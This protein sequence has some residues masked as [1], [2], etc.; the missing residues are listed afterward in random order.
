MREVGERRIARMRDAARVQCAPASDSRL[1]PDSVSRIPHRVEPRTL[2]ASGHRASSVNDLRSNGLKHRL[3]M[4][5]TLQDTVMPP[6]DEIP[7]GTLDML[8]LRTLA[9]RDG[10]A[11]VRDRRVHSLRLER[12]AAGGGRVALP[13][14]A[15]HAH[16]GVDRGRVGE[17]RGE[18]AGAILPAHG[19]RQAAARARNRFVPARGAAPS[20]SSSGRREARS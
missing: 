20:R 17:D 5:R 3:S 2:A 18:P 4:S 11:R 9:R 7:P 1:A 14:A 15:A 19:G 10:P 12:R 13:G 16:E 6:R 8:I